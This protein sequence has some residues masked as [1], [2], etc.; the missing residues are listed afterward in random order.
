MKTVFVLVGI[1]ILST[2]SAMPLR[3]V[4]ARENEAP[5]Q[6]ISDTLTLR[7]VTVKANFSPVTRSPMRL[8]VI[9]NETIR[10]RAG[11]RTYPE[12]LK[13][14]PSLYATSESG[15]YGDAKLNV[16]GF[17][18][19]NI[20]VMLNGIPI[21]G[22]VS[23]NMYW[24]NWMGLADATYAIQVQKGIGSSMLSDSSVG[25]TVNII[26]D[27]SAETLGGEAGFYGTS[28][29]TV[30]GYLKFNSGNLPK[31]WAIG[32]MASYVGG[33]GYVRATSVN[34]FAYMLNVSKRFGPDHTL[35]FTALGSPEQHDQRS[36]R[37]S[38][39]E[40]QRYGLKYSKNWGWRDGREFS[41]S[42]NTYFKPY[43][44]LQHIWN[45][46]R[47]SMKNSVY[48]A[49]ANGGGRWNETK[50]APIATFLKDGQI[51]WESVTAA[52]PEGGAAQNIL[53]DYLAG[54][55]QIGAIS[56]IEYA[57][58]QGWKIGAG[59]HYLY[60]STWECEKISDLLGAGYWFE[61]YEKKSLA[62]LAGRDP[63][64]RVGDYIRTDNGKTTNLG[65]AYF[66]ASYSSE[67]LQA[68]LGAS[69][70]G[71]ANRR[72]D[73]YN[74]VGDDIFSDLAGG[75]G[76]SFK[77]GVLY[78]PGK[79]HSIYLN[80]GWYSRLPYSSVWFSSGNNEI[81]KDV[82]NERNIL[83]ETG[84][85]FVWDR[86]GLELTA[87]AAWWKNK[88]LMSNPFKQENAYDVKYMVTGLN[89]FHCGIEAEVFHRFTDWLKISAFASI[90]S[91]R[92]Q[93]DVQ[94]SIY[95]DYS[96]LELGKVNV[97]CAGL[98]VGDAPQ[99]Q[100]GADLDIDIPGGFRVA[101]DWK[102]NDRMYADFDPVTRIDPDD[103]RTAYRFPSCHLLGATVSWTHT[104]KRRLDP[105]LTIFAGV[106]N[107]LDT[108][109]I[110]RGK[111]GAGHDLA[112][113]T[114]YWGFGR[115]FSFGVRLSL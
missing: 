27:P 32:L 94:A 64:K 39:D 61:D 87:Y 58:R 50:G 4:P 106:S 105:G 36:S 62:G 55:T 111:D 102:F 56:S 51:D 19:A 97:Y 115:T 35:I 18:Q 1:A 49:F 112:S 22:L 2:A 52:N 9:D 10:E 68:N 41:L 47:I 91:W 78:R 3:D 48:A 104:P 93:N 24:N 109:Y 37:L 79:G 88:S 7:E 45:G 31:G 82:K 86:G 77:G 8:S 67:K 12:M 95:D 81:T 5:N 92:W 101:V 99:T 25:G 72:W 21:S 96:G 13:G 108:M 90:G 43:F 63:Y 14:I 23:G 59:L 98:P 30:K 33:E 110:E 28:Y 29:G 15:S 85:R 113:F 75:V 73:R 11:S 34:S 17:Q 26:T 103:R 70:Y 83:A 71:S 38:W 57:L 20:S 6:S 80:G 40:V 44:T 107:L 84:W 42:R 65:T 114:G 60:Y 100:V 46:D 76:A 89:A 69:L 53:S 16:R 66:S 54:H 74:Y